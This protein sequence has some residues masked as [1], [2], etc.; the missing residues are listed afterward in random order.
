MSIS[1]DD[2]L[3]FSTDNDDIN[4]EMDESDDIDLL[5]SPILQRQTGYYKICTSRSHIINKENEN[6]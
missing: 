5:P 6:T 3:S 1:N 2:K 4:N